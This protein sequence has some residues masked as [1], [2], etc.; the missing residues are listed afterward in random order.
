MW[1]GACVCGAGAGKTCKLMA[2]RSAKTSSC[3]AHSASAAGMAAEATGD[4]SATPVSSKYIATAKLT[5]SFASLPMPQKEVNI[6]IQTLIQTCAL[7]VNLGCRLTE[8]SRK[9][10]LACSL[11]PL[12]TLHTHSLHTLTRA[13]TQLTHTPDQGPCLLIGE[14]VKNHL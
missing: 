7:H 8:A 3:S 6:R 4:S 12:L 11:H 9:V 5:S 10:A 14:M 13:V 1:C 2:A